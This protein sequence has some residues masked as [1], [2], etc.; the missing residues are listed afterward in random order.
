MGPAVNPSLLESIRQGEALEMQPHPRRNS[1]IAPESVQPQ[2]MGGG[3]QVTGQLSTPV[4]RVMSNSS[5][6]QVRARG[7][8]SRT[9]IDRALA[10]FKGMVPGAQVRS[11]IIDRRQPLYPTLVDRE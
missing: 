2:N 8:L 4:A 1:Q 7:D 9:N 10:Q 5:S 3:P 11:H 6:L